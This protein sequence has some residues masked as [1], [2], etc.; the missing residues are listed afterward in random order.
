MKN[1]RIA[2]CLSGLIGSTSKGGK[3]K[4]INFYKTKV[5]FDKNLISKNSKV[6]YFLQCWNEEF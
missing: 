1:V 2:I 5:Y 4:H 3:G 6:D